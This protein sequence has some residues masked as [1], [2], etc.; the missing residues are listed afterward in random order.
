M[1]KP[2]TRVGLMSL[3]FLLVLLCSGDGVS[4]VGAQ[5]GARR[6]VAATI[7][8]R[9]EQDGG[10]RLHGIV[11]VLLSSDPATRFKVLARTATDGDGRYVLSNVPPGRYQ[12]RPLAAAYVV[13]NLTGTNLSGK[14]IIIAAGESVEDFDFTLSRG[15]VITGR[16][17]DADGHPLI[18]ETVTLSVVGPNRVGNV[19]PVDTYRRTTDDRGVYRIFGLPAG[20]YRVSAGLDRESGNVRV[21]PNGFYPRIFYPGTAHEM[22]AKVVEVKAGG[23]VADID[24][25]LGKRAKTFKASGRVVSAASGEPVPGIRVGY[26][27]ASRLEGRIV[28]MGIAQS[29]AR[30]EFQLGALAMGRYAVFAATEGAADW[31]SD[32]APFEVDQS[33]VVGLEIKI[34]RGGSLVGAV[35]IEGTRDRAKLARLI[36]QIH[37]DVNY[38]E[39]GGL[40]APNYYRPLRPAPDGSFRVGGL[41]P[42]RVRLATG[43]P[44]V[45]GLTLLRVE[46][47]GVERSDGIEVGEGARVTGV[48]AV[49]AYGNAAVRGEVN[50]TGG[51]LPPQS[52][53][54]AFVLR[55]GGSGHF[56][57]RPADVDARGR[58]TVEGLP[59]G[60]YELVVQARG[61]GM[62]PRE[63]K[64]HITLAEDGEATV[65]LT[66]DLSAENNGAMP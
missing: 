30:G 5:T 18:R 47:D 25:T 12:I 32:A 9:V 15:G 29:D 59:S 60:D 24:I 33:D 42:S 41:R 11:V 7:S 23:E 27:A 56:L 35:L 54:V 53:L 58:F 64:Q 22:E 26:G 10:G 17:T 39:R 63:I 6:E 57:G 40:A 8:G 34:R 44:L 3:V 66:L 55:P 14:Q 61:P 50:V 46:H 38:E 45:K 65:S 28:W 51:V 62:R 1:L 2:L 43:W 36:S 19:G 48:R 49:Y 31:Y 4:D 52:R 37:L 20:S 21:G 16:V 13:A